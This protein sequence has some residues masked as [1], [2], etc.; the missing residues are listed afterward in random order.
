MA[1]LPPI[2]QQQQQQFLQNHHS[3]HP[4]QSHPAEHRGQ[5]IYTSRHATFIGA[6]VTAKNAQI[7]AGGNLTTKAALDQTLTTTE[8]NASHKKSTLG[9]FNNN[10]NSQHTQQ[11][12]QYQIT[13]NTFNIK[14]NFY[15]HAQGKTY[16]E[17]IDLNAQNAAITGKGKVLITEAVAQNYD[18]T[19]QQSQKSRTGLPGVDFSLAQ[20]RIGL[21]LAEQ[22]NRQYTRHQTFYTDKASKLNVKGNLL[23]QSTESTITLANTQT[24]IEKDLVL[25]GKLGALITNTQKQNTDKIFEQNQKTTTGI[26]LKNHFVGWCGRSFGQL[27]R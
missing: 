4:T 14:N 24:N 9:M 22:K 8:N 26:G 12:L 13:G 27:L 25:D 21:T 20:G 18:H 17:G 10:G 11:S 19:T 7:L 5:P 6:V 16:M 2:F 3:N 23:V 1:R 15:T